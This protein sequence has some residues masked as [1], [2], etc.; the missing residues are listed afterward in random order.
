[1]HRYAH[2]TT[3]C[4]YHASAFAGRI[5]F[6]RRA[7]PSRR[8]E[9]LRRLGTGEDVKHAC[10]FIAAASSAAWV[11]L[12]LARGGFWRVRLDEHLPPPPEAMPSVAAVIPAR[13]E[14]DGIAVALR[15]LAA[16]NYD[17]SLSITLVD[18]RST[19]ATA[20]IA[21]DI[22][23]GAV[24]SIAVEAARDLEPGWTG[25]L[26]A[27]ATGVA[28][29][30]SEGPHYWLFTDGDIAHDP[31]NVA[32]LVALAQRD[33]LDL[34]SL[35]VRLRCESAWERLLVPAFVFFFAK[36][37]PFAWSND[38]RRTTAAAAGGCVL[39]RAEALERIGGLAAI[40]GELIDDCALAARVKGSGGR[41]WLGW[42]DRTTSL[43]SYDDLAT[44]W[45][46]VKRTAFTQLRRSYTI[47]AGTLAGLGLLY[48]A[49]P[50]LLA[51]GIVA[52]DVRLTLVAAIAIVAQ[53]IAYRPT[54]RAYARPTRD[55]LALPF[56]AVLYSAMTVDSAATA[57]AGRHG[58]W[59]GRSYAVTSE[60]LASV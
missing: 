4:S 60:V 8:M 26:N 9:R 31:E 58:S 45:T 5:A 46:M 32:G 52:R 15:S 42:S 21:R 47:T 30:A 54:L 51:R 48:C 22:A 35:M 29:R 6:R 19:D 17:G 11:G 14:A 43:R 16:Q 12:L 57:L 23:H 44:I 53:V 36:L 40:R 41:I 38:V 7:A 34:A 59:K 49:P 55:A 28:L 27:L 18:D 33:G 50:L 24:R 37:Y 10:L 56:A 2:G 13:D 1:M 3:R 25:K 20:E 39:V